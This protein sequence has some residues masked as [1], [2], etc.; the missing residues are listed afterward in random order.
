MSK[1]ITMNNQKQDLTIKRNY[2]NNWLFLFSEYQLIKEKKHLKLKTVNELFILH[3]IPRQTFY[4]Y[5]HRYKQ[6]KDP[7][8]LLPQKRGPKWASRRPDISIEK[9]VVQERLKG[10]N[11]YEIYQVLF[12]KLESKTPSYSGIYNILKRKKMNRLRPK[13]EKRRIIKERAGQLGH[14]DCHY[15]SKDLFVGEYKR[16]YL[17]AIIDSYSRLAWSELIHDIKSLTTMFTALKSINLLNVGYGIN[18]E[19]ILSDNGSEFSSRTTKSREHHPFERMLQELGIKHRYIRP[20]RPQTNGKVERFW[21]TI[22]EELIKG[23][24]FKDEKEF[25]E[26][27]QKYMFYYNEHRAHQALEGMNPK[28]YHEK[29]LSTN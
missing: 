9:Q 19:E 3:N 28:D 13:E 21:R 20:Y 2:T 22:N 10:M 29:N 18:F 23:T 24:T 1:R 4:K 8:A 7:E 16:Y 11:K 26:E 25:R 17:F 27:L 15:L 5:Y 6:S 12:P 14:V